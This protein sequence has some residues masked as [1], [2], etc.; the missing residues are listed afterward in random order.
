M[1][2]AANDRHLNTNV[3]I[4][5]EDDLLPDLNLFE[6]T[7]YLA[8]DIYAANHER[9][10]EIREYAVRMVRAH[11]RTDLCDVRE[12]FEV[13]IIPL[14]NAYSEDGRIMGRRAR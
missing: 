10:A 12:H 14:V 1:T 4:Y 9:L 3:V 5:G 8:T 7:G 6:D 13:I 11:F 2:I